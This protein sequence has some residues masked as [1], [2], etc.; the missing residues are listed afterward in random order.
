MENTSITMFKQSQCGQ[1]VTV[2]ISLDLLAPSSLPHQAPEQFLESPRIKSHS[3]SQ[4]SILLVLSILFHC[5]V[6]CCQG[7]WCNEVIITSRVYLRYDCLQLLSCKYGKQRFCQWTIRFNDSWE[8]PV[9]FPTPWFPVSCILTM[10][11]TALYVLS[12]GSE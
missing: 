8:V 7:F 6:T 1:N 11:E 9:T 2:I 4:L 5:L 10:R 12:A 3:Y